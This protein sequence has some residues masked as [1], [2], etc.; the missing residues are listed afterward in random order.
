MNPSPKKTV[1]RVRTKTYS[2]T[3]YLVLLAVAIQFSVIIWNFSIRS[4]VKIDIQAP[5]LPAEEFIAPPPVAAPNSVVTETKVTKPAPLGTPIASSSETPT[6]KE[7][8]QKLLSESQRFLDQAEPSLARNALLE[9]ES[10]EPDSIEVIT[11]IIELAEKI[12]NKELASEY[13]KRLT[14]LT[15]ISHPP[16]STPVEKT[17]ASLTP[18]PSPS[19]D[20]PRAE[21]TAP[22]PENT[23]SLLPPKIPPIAP[24]VPAPYIQAV[25]PSDPSA[26]RIVIGALEKKS[27]P[28]TNAK[29]EFL[30]KIPILANPSPEGVEPGK[31]SIKLYFYELQTDGKIVPSNA[32]LDV[33]FE[34][35][36]PNWSSRSENLNA[37]YSLPTTQAS[38]TYYGYR[39]KIYYKGQFQ[40]EISEPANLN[41]KLP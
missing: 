23:N 22:N 24:V 33:S 32:R 30:L 41:D 9:A 2:V 34:N 37:L 13:Q 4:Q 10:L 5:E 14:Q 6:L 21:K 28:S 39:L 1:G 19:P 36:R 20:S 29:T 18:S 35:K 8:V 26:K 25:T 17:I 38:R 12:Q 7:R 27:I 15:G 16:V 3:L 40:D 31:I 11:K